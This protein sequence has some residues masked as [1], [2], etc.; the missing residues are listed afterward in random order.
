CVSFAAAQPKDSPVE[1]NIP[2]PDA[3]RRPSLT[4]RT[5]GV[6]DLE[7]IAARAT[8][9]RTDVNTSLIVSEV[10]ERPVLGSVFDEFG[11]DSSSLVFHDYYR[12]GEPKKLIDDCLKK[13]RQL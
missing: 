9:D 10:D 12:V 4:P 11:E 2:T 7:A 13:E 1:S 5:S 6:C 8:T 3:M